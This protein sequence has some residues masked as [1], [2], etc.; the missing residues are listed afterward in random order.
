MERQPCDVDSDIGSHAPPLTTG[1]GSQSSSTRG[2]AE[3]RAAKRLRLTPT[4]R[5]CLRTF[6]ESPD[7]LDLEGIAERQQGSWCVPCYNAWRTYYG[8]QGIPLTVFSKT[9]EDSS[10]KA[11][12]D[13][14]LAAWLTL[15]NEQPGDGYVRAPALTARVDSIRLALRLLGYPAE[16]CMT[17]SLRDFMDGRF[18]RPAG[19]QPKTTD[20]CNVATPDGVAVGLYV[21]LPASS[22]S[23]SSHTF[24]K[25]M[26]KDELAM[27]RPSVVS[28]DASERMHRTSNALSPCSPR[29]RQPSFRTTT[30]WTS[31]CSLRHGRSALRP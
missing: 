11:K 15:R 9:L 12:W 5:S 28:A 6:G 7:F 24:Q 19:W 1:S 27:A 13:I 29:V 23:S 4:C 10:E 31:S 3:D 26:S 16:P 18:Q 8:N 20:I 14:V 30:P 22:S 17:V 21:P 2:D 25:P